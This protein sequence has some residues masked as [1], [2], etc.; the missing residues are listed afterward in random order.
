[1]TI[2]PSY[3]YQFSALLTAVGSLLLVIL[4]YRKGVNERLKRQFTLYY[5]S[6][7]VWSLSVFICT[8]VY[9]YQVSYF[10]NQATHAAAIMI[11]VFFLHFTLVY[12]G[13]L[14]NIIEKVVLSSFYLIA[15]FF[16]LS[17]IF[18]SD[19]FFHGIE[20]KLSFPLF[21]TAGPLYTPWVI[22]FTA[23]VMIAHL[24]LFLE[25]LSAKG[26]RKKQIA[27][28]LI[29]NLLGYMGGIGCFIPVYGLS[30]FPFPY[31]PYGVFL[32]SLVSGYAILKHRLIDLEILIRK[33]IIF[34]SLFAAIFAVFSFILL[35]FQGLLSRYMS[36]NPFLHTAVSI[37]VIV[38]IYNPL[39]SYLINLTDRFLFQKKYDYR[40][41][42]KDA[43]AGI[44]Q[45]KSLN[46]LLSLVVHFITMRLRTR[47]ASMLLHDEK[48]NY[49]KSAFTRGYPV[50]GWLKSG[51]IFNK[52]DPLIDYLEH[53][54]QP[55]DI[56]RVKEYIETGGPKT[57]KGSFVRQYDYKLI[58][59][60]MDELL[61]ACCVPSFLG[62]RLLGVL[63]LGEKKSGDA[64]SDEDLAVLFTIAQESAIAIENAR[65]YDEAIEKAKELEIINENLNSAQ[66]SLLRALKDTEAA[67]RKLQETQAALISAQKKATMVGMAQAIGHEVYNPLVPISGKAQHIYMIHVKKYY[68][69]LNKYRQV[70]KEEDARA[71][72]KT[73]KETDAYAHAIVNNVDRV[74]GVVKSLTGTLKES[75]GE[76]GPLSVVVLFER[77]LQVSRFTTGEENLAGCEVKMDITDKLMVRGNPNQLDEVFLNLIKNAYEAM[78]Q[79]EGRRIDI[80]VGI[81]AQNHGMARID[82][83]DNG[84]GIPPEILPK[85][86]QQ[87]FSTKQLKGDSIGASGQGHGL[88]VCKHIIEGFHGGTITVTSTLGKGTTFIIKLPVAEAKD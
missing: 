31:G 11:P 19:L 28:F 54:H 74:H 58:K 88:F 24:I 66:T 79:K 67:N 38:L 17:V 7:F 55:I 4:V 42:L 23:A 70:M 56:E 69:I 14:K 1:M 13:R 48:N 60:R 45:I 20:P 12:L 2:L 75:S 52:Q 22:S 72:E 16:E 61:A 18:F 43:A 51:H 81:D 86:W 63:V 37:L 47:N 82:F 57:K 39:R 36:S 46:Q 84:P 8:S 73:I 49:F 35:I 85:I 6:L 65:L 33:T 77:V 29:A 44:S 68:D 78:G 21:P 34:G 71:M 87:G 30:Y 27:F 15:L 59:V 53:E 80:H 64:Y 83:S 40:K 10:F 25:L 9:N 5:A 41:L 76:M 26:L 32:L 50:E 62:K 3:H